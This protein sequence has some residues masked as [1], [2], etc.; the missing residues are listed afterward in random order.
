MYN[1]II[2]YTVSILLVSF[3][4]L[5]LFFKNIFYSLLSAICVFF[6]TAILF[7]FLGSEYNAIIQFAIY[8]FAVP[9][10]LGLGIMFTNLKNKPKSESKRQ[11][12]GYILALIAGIFLI[13]MIYLVMIS[14]VST[15]DELIE[16]ISP[17][18][19]QN[20]FNN[21]AIFAKGFFVDYVWAFELIS[22]V[23]TVSAIGLTLMEKER[24]GR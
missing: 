14:C 7:L 24:Q 21:I 17:G 8:G 18:V 16:S 9:V 11:N 19:E 2:F 4:I 20:T 12:L 3:G 15:P 13:A 22:I 1:H 10:I 6:L 5:T 23:I